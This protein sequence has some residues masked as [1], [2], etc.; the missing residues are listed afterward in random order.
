M[1]N[2]IKRI[3]PLILTVAIILCIG[4]YL[5]V[6]DRTFTRDMM[7]NMA[8]VTDMK[9]NQKL[10]SFFYDRAYVYSGNDDEVAIELA[11]Q[12]KDDGNFTK[13]EYTLSTA[14]ASNPTTNLYIALSKTYVQQDKLLDAVNMLDNVA[15]PVIRAELDSLRPASPTATPDPG[16]YS[17]YVTVT[18][19]SENGSLYFNTDGEYPSTADGAYSEPIVLPGGETA[20]YCIAVAKNGLVSPVT[21]LAYTVGGVIEPVTIEDP[22]MNAEIRRILAVDEDDVLYT[23]DLWSI[24]EF[25]VPADAQNCSELARMPYL[26]KLTIEKKNLES[27]S[28]LSGMTQLQ[29]LNLTGCRFPSDDLSIV[30]LLPG[31]NKLTLNACGLST[32][33]YLAPAANLS[34]LDL[35]N[36]TIRNLTYL[37]GMTTLKELYLQHNAVMDL[38]TLSELTGLKILDISYN[39]VSSLA[40]LVA[41]ADLTDLNARNNSISTVTAVDLLPNL[42]YL[43]LNSNAI[44]D[45]TVL[46]KCVNLTEIHV[47]YNQ[48]KNIT[49]FSALTK[50]DVLDFSH[51][52]V[53]EVPIWPNDCPLRI[54]DGSYNKVSNVDTLWNMYKLTYIYMDYNNITSLRNLASMPNLVQI[55][56]YGNP[57]EDLTGLE[58]KNII[59]NYDPTK[60]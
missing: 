16:F 27:L 54:L 12:Y 47:A 52:S 46:G 39:S 33:E 25:T 31:L 35:S 44:S 28:F 38:T 32:I 58:A 45:A 5:F 3:V 11:N 57:I 51:N 41:C 19:E 59:V 15:D 4:W 14:I 9:G 21:V 17:Q 30:A 23:N 22:A 36:N 8:R 43:N 37:S 53:Y 6:Y 34:Y 50:L 40:P 1:N 49:M 26:Q 42:S 2:A 48:L 7:L 10:A 18:L 60:G 29:E 13:A 55:N 20:I 24:T 56:V